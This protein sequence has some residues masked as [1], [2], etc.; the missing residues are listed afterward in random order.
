MIKRFLAMLTVTALL[1]LAVVSYYRTNGTRT[2]GIY[3]EAVG[4]RPDAAVLYVNGEPVCA[5]EYLYWL[6]SVCEYLVS[7]LG[8]T[9]DFN[10]AVTEEMTLGE[11]A[12][13]DAANTSIL[14]A[15]VRQLAQE[16][17]IVL[18][19][20]D[21]DELALQRSQYVAY[22]GSE[23]AYALQLQVL[24]LT[25]ERL[26]DIE[27]VPYLYSRLYQQFS[28]PD[29]KLYP[30]EDALRQF[31]DE[32]GYVTAQLL[33]LTTAGLDEAAMADMALRAADF[34]AQLRSAADKQATYRTLAESLG[35]TVSDAGF[36]F[37]AADSD[38]A[39]HAAAA[40]LQTGQ[41][42]DAIRGE[43]G[44]YVAL[45]MDTNYAALA[46]HLFNIYLQEWQD[47]AKV[48]YSESLYDSID[49][50][51]FYIA[52]SQARTALLQSATLAAPMP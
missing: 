5:E 50:G 48:E 10:S 4:I 49:A 51:A 18:T 27:A 40:A 33:Y 22:Y 16:H 1:L 28:D 26:L 7:Y 39:V 32:N 30:G 37:C 47:S 12:K 11:Y 38:A 17:D 19:Q 15:L 2:D 44:Y 43:S 52:L 42:S 36:T 21:I 46:E 23:E 45:R 3:Y 6:D 8:S 14:Y 41:V 35:L 29:G 31:G 9:P 24:G 34:A 20:E 13:A 25:E